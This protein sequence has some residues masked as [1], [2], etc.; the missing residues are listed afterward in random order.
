MFVAGFIFLSILTLHQ[1]GECY[2]PIVNVQSYIRDIHKDGFQVALDASIAKKEG[3]T[4]YLSSNGALTL[5]YMFPN[6]H[7]LFSQTKFSYAKKDDEAT[8]FVN[9]LFEH[10]RFK[11]SLIDEW[12]EMEAFG[13]YSFD[14]RKR[15]ATRSLLGGGPRF[16]IYSTKSEQYY[17][18]K[19]VIV[20]NKRYYRG[21][22]AKTESRTSKKK[23]LKGKKIT[24][25]FQI[26]VGT[27]YMFEY[28]ALDT[29][30]PYGDAGSREY[31][32][33]WSNYL[34]LSMIFNEY[35]AI[36][37]TFYLQ[38][39]LNQFSDYRFLSENSLEFTA[40]DMIKF[41]VTGTISYDS[42]PPYTVKSL[43]SSITAGIRFRFS[44]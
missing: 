41:I 23:V 34:D 13:Q 21:R 10:I 32:H 25:G 30:Q 28:N 35:F 19:E 42:A 37:S 15:L 7:L 4:Q 40:N 39:R 8:P 36:I 27:A 20:T 3:N 16:I 12:L 33:R 9:N 2:S 26:A 43:D 29:K 1:T 38:P 17:E 18:S 11:Y 22:L 14:E 5:L 44:M 31:F 24:G 6:K